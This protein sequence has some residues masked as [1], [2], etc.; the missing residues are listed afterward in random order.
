M[1]EGWNV[2]VSEML[3]FRTLAVF[4][5]PFVPATDPV[6]LPGQHLVDEGLHEERYGN[7]KDHQR[8]DVEAQEVQPHKPIKS[9]LG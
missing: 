5:G 2:P 7:L 1:F 4:E 8:H 3:T 9:R 6:S